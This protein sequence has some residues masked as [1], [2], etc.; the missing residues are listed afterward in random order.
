M[1]L[2][3]SLYFARCLPHFRS[4]L[5]RLYYTCSRT[6][7]CALMSTLT[8]V[9]QPAY[10]EVKAHHEP[11]DVDL[12]TWLMLYSSICLST[13]AFV[14]LCLSLCLSVS[15]FATPESLRMPGTTGH[16]HVSLSVSSFVCPCV[17][18]HVRISV[19]VHPFNQ[20]E[21]VHTCKW[22]LCVSNADTP[23]CV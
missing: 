23:T 17:P 14:R 4:F 21:Q 15:S 19:C 11:V 8:R 18:T 9:T 2:F 6:Y 5:Q 12:S 20:V 22:Q 16:M 7:D 10:A 3:P 1:K 13:R